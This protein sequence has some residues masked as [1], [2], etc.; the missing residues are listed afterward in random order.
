MG[1]LHVIPEMLIKISNEKVVHV[2][3]PE[4]TR[5]MCFVDD[6]VEMTIRACENKYTDKMVLNIGNQNQEISIINLTKK[7]ANILNKNIE[8]KKLPDTGDLQK[9]MSRH[10]K[11]Y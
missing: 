10:F 7:I 11:N 1:F 2:A 3:S 9:K 4:H 6:A 5:S 8:I